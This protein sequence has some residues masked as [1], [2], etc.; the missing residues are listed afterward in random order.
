MNRNYMSK[1]V[2]LV[3]LLASATVFGLVS[4]NALALTASNTTISNIATL[5]YSV[6]AVLQPVMES[7]VAG[8]NTPGVGNGTA[9]TFLVDKKVNLTVVEADSTFHPTVPSQLATSGLNTMHFSITNLGND[10]QDFSLA[11]AQAAS[12]Q[13]LFG[14]TDSYDSTGCTAYIDA[15]ANSIFD[16]GEATFIDE[17]AS[18]ASQVIAVSCDTPALLPNT[19][20]S[21]TTL[22]AQVLTGGTVGTQGVAM[23]NSGASA[24]TAGVDIVFADSAGSTDAVHDAIH[25]AQDAYR[26]GTATITVAKTVAI[27][28]DPVNGVSTPHNIPGA[29][30]RYVI[31]ISNAAGASPATLASISDVLDANLTL[32]ANLVTS[33][34]T[35]VTPESAAGSGFKVTVLAST[36]AGTYPKFFTTAADTDAVGISG[37]TVSAVISAALPVESGYAAGELRGG[38]SVL[39][40]FNVTVN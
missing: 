7:S 23:I 19:S 39:L 37:S 15:N 8:N 22:S 1:P 12:G 30:L 9:T 5:T 28:C 21:I 25:S 17:L 24:N 11:T 26:V 10:P 18:L 31:A 35:C 6:S 13:I 27:L 14:G 20:V 3:A 34:S 40:T 33:A 4:Q 29:T 36:R 38:E 32:D 16:A 2:K